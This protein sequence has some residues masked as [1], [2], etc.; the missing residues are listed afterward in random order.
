MGMEHFLLFAV[1]LILC[2]GVGV[3]FLIAVGA[4]KVKRCGA[5]CELSMRMRSISGMVCIG[6][7]IALQFL[8]D[9]TI[10]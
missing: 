4:V 9:G 5:W 1:G 7:L 3:S 10:T 6:C 2:L 8:P